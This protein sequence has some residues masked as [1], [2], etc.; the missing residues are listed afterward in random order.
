MTAFVPIRE[1]IARSCCGVNSVNNSL[2]KRLRS[3]L[4][5]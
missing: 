2:G 1:L 5:A 4:L 3:L